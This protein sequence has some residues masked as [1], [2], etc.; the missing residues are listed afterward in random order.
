MRQV[1]ALVR[2]VSRSRRGF[3]FHDSVNYTSGS[4]LLIRDR[5]E[6]DGETTLAACNGSDVDRRTVIQ[7]FRAL[8]G[9]ESDQPE[10][11]IR[12]V[13]YGLELASRHTALRFQRAGSLPRP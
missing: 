4:F 2:H 5:I 9:S 6:F 11:R 12:V 10:V 3:G 8:Q 13:D 7:A 1:R